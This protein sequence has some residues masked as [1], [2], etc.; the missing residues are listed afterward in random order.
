MEVYKKVFLQ[1]CRNGKLIGVK[2][3]KHNGD[4]LRTWAFKIDEKEAKKEKFD[5]TIIEGSFYET[6]TYP[7]CPYCK[8]H[9]FFICG[10]CKK[11]NCYNGEKEATCNW[12]KITAETNIVNNFKIQSGEF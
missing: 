10:T 7:G 12:C 11:I 5:D 8:S 9:S 4:W 6:E 3:E 1:K 2:V